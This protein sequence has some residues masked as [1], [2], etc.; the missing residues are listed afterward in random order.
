MNLK[1]YVI[2]KILTNF[3]ALV[4]LLFTGT[5][6]THAQTS[7]Y[8]DV[9][10][11]GEVNITDVN[12]V[13]N[14]IMGGHQTM[15]IVGSWYSEYF[16]DQDGRYDVPDPIAVGFD[17]YSDHTGRYFF[18]EN[19]SMVGL[20]LRWSLQDQRLYIWYDNDMYEEYFCRIDE[21]GYLLLTF[22]PQFRNYTAYRPLPPQ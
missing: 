21:N 4:L 8:G 12:E 13:V 7:I 6:A 18:R 10:G 11:D 2:M 17:F 1:N 3:T 15:N 22:D 20:D 16:V 9:N 5:F 19:G 14:V